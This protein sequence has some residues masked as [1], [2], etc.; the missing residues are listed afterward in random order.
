MTTVDDFA[1]ARIGLYSYYRSLTTGGF[2]ITPEIQCDAFHAVAGFSNAYGNQYRWDFQ[3]SDGNVEAIWASYYA[4]IS[5]ANYFIDSYQKAKKGEKG[6]FT[7]EELKT[8]GAYA[9][10]AYFTRAYGYLHLANYYCEAY[11]TLKAKIGDKV[12]SDV[13]LSNLATR[14][15]GYSNRDIKNFIENMKDSLSDEFNNSQ[16]R[17]ENKPFEQFRFTN[18]MI[19]KAFAEIPP[20]TKQGDVVRIERFKNEGE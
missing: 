17:G 12:A 3:P 9:A 14:L 15:D 19:D 16:A 2:I 7:N 20:T 4:H 1:N 6:K 8:L 11:D 10:E 13:D 18:A 5:R